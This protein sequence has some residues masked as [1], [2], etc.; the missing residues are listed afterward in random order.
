[1]YRTIKKW[2]I[3]ANSLYGHS[4]DEMKD[5]VYL[6]TFKKI[7]DIR[8]NCMDIFFYNRMWQRNVWDK[9]Q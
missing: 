1:M 6:K 2:I 7:H 3:Y 8:N 4:G 5:K 9:L